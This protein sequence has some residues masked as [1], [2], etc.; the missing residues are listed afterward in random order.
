MITL[1][2]GGWLAAW[3]GARHQLVER[4]E[5]VFQDREILYAGPGYDGH[6]DQVVDRPA[7][8]IC[9]GFINLHGHVGV[10]P[11]AP[12]VDIPRSGQFAPGPDF[13]ENAP[14]SM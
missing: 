5:V 9:P 13:V 12:L 1:L 8:F 6:V 4:G 2:R 11:M 3:D 10:D 7:W 14:L